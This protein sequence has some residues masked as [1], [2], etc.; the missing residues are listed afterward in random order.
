MKKNKTVAYI[1]AAALLIGGAGLGTKALFSDSAT[2]NGN[3][4]KITM[5]NL[6]IKASESDWKVTSGDGTEVK[7][8]DASNKFTNVK[9]GDSFE[10]T[11]ILDN[12]GSLDQM[13]TISGGTLKEGK[14]I[15]SDVIIDNG[16]D[17]QVKEGAFLLKE[18][19]HTEFKITVKVN[20]NVFGEYGKQGSWNLES[21]CGADYTNLLN[22]YSINAE[23]VKVSL[24]QEK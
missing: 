10:K 22:G 6:H 7:Q 12:E 11:V 15:S 3:D 16:L 23:Q 8:G 5:G 21:L 9:P 19:G 14:N 17:K 24:S 2:A 4:L 1:M 18:G 20:E 13:V